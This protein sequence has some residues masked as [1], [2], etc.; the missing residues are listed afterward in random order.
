MEQAQLSY[1]S[2][3]ALQ[4]DWAEC[5]FEYCTEWVAPKKSYQYRPFAKWSEKMQN[6]FFQL[7]S[8]HNLY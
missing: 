6:P 5:V 8:V 7:I 3:L 2:L 1:F 4:I